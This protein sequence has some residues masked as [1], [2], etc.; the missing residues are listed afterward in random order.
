[1]SRRPLAF[2]YTEIC[3]VTAWETVALARANTKPA[4]RGVEQSG[5]VRKV[6]LPR[7]DED[8]YP[9]RTG[10]RHEQQEPAIGTRLEPGRGQE[11]IARQTHRVADRFV[12]V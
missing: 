7:G 8:V 1:M 3:K 9:A 12:A 6:V 4:G 11:V 5:G 2:R 10:D